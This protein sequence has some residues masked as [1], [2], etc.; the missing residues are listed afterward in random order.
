LDS[1]DQFVAATDTRSAP[2]GTTAPVGLTPAQVRHAYGF[3]QVSFGNIVGDGSGQT[4]AIVVAYDHPGFVSSTSPNFASSDLHHFDEQMGIADPPTF[5]K[6]DEFGGTNYP[7]SNAAWA[8]ETAL[9]VE[10]IHALAPGA[11]IVLVESNSPYNGDMNTAVETA[12]SY[13][14][15][16]VL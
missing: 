6:I 2:L 16:S 15:V 1:S 5:T 9:D 12:R 13:P 3:D 11:N 14:G 10:W 8:N 4:I 7:A